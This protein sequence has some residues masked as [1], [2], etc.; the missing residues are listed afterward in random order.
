MEVVFDWPHAIKLSGVFEKAQ[1]G[2]CIY[3]VLWP[4]SMHV[5]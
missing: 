3:Y 1:M 5:L 4:F 2:Y